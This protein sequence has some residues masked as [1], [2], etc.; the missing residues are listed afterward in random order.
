MH[1]VAITILGSV[2]RQ[3]AARSISRFIVYLSSRSLLRK[4]NTPRR[5]APRRR[6]WANIRMQL[7]HFANSVIAWM[8]C[9]PCLFNT[10]QYIYLRRGGYSAR[11]LRLNGARGTATRACSARRLEGVNVNFMK[12]GLTSKTTPSRNAAPDGP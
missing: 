9:G 4:I 10:R 2:I 7:Q 8:K 3:P 5:A 1:E 12:N 11:N 6:C